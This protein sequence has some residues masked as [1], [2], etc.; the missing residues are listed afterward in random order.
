[1]I[2]EKRKITQYR[3]KR[4]GKTSYRKRLK[5]LSSN[6]L[7]LVVRKSLKNI[8]AQL[9]EYSLDGDKVVLGV[10]S[11]ELKKKYKWSFSRKNIS[12]SYLTGLLLGTKAKKKQIKEAILDIGLEKSIKGGKIYAVLKGVLDAG[13]NIQHSKEMLPKDDII[14][15]DNISKHLKISDLSKVVEE[16]KKKI[17]EG[18]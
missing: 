7:R 17:L 13:L 2:K 16:I 12:A 5:L 15:G 3:R 11:T 1:M 18:K 10:S 8:T 14:K 6:K 4:E 9:I